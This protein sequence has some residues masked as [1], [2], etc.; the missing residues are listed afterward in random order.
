MMQQVA[1]SGTEAVCRL[2]GVAVSHL[3]AVVH[4][5]IHA[6]QLLKQLQRAAHGQHLHVEDA[7]E[8]SLLW[9][10]GTAC[11]RARACV[12]MCVHGE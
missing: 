9:P 11:M 6:G 2:S 5:R 12:C 7:A 1:S 8:A 4:E 10:V 3:W